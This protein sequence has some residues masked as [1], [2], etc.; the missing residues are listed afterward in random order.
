MK[1]T[2]IAL[3]PQAELWF[4]VA[5]RFGTRQPVTPGDGIYFQLPGQGLD[6]SMQERLWLLSLP[7][8]YLAAVQFD[9]V[10]VGRISKRKDVSS[11]ALPTTAAAS[12]RTMKIVVT[13]NVKVRT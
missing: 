8:F 2:S 13:Y 7:G 4:S 1:Q 6:L 11:T 5:D 10:A 9:V 12:L 3:R